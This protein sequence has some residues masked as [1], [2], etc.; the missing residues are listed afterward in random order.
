M[1]VGRAD[2]RPAFLPT[3]YVLTMLR[4]RNR[5]SSTIAHHL[6]SIDLLY[7]IAHANG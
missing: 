1:L 3:I 6:R 4:A 7:R 2:G 5:Q